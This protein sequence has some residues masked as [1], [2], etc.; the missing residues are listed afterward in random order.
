M[1]YNKMEYGINVN[2][3]SLVKKFGKKAGDDVAGGVFD[4]AT[5]SKVLRH[6]A[7]CRYRA[8]HHR[9]ATV[10][11][12]SLLLQTFF[13]FLIKLINYFFW[14]NRKERER[15]F[16]KR[17]GWGEVGPASRSTCEGGGG[18]FWLCEPGLHGIWWEKGRCVGG[19]PRFLF[20][21][22]VSRFCYLVPF[23]NGCVSHPRTTSIPLGFLSSAALFHLLPPLHFPFL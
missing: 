14:F 2:R 16:E 11:G 23:L 19:P 17:E 5:D 9:T 6:V 12:S 7:R 8:P 18:G 13:I 22:A 10:S 1:K 15:E 21:S 4:S 3:K 20:F